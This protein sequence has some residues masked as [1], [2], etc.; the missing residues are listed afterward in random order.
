MEKNIKKIPWSAL[1]KN[2]DGHVTVVVQDYLTLQVLMVAYM[3][4]EAYNL[5][6]ENGRMTYF[7]RS[8]NALWVKGETSGHY[9][10]V[11]E[12]TADCDMDTL[13][14]QVEQI[15]NACHTGSYSCFFNRII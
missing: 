13:L 3:N 15:G 10:Y 9:Q 12:L 4:E 1:K 6:L 5:T 7:S 11:K 14:A 2:S 8:R